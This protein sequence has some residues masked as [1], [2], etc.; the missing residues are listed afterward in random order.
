LEECSHLCSCCGE[1]LIKLQETNYQ[2]Y[3]E[4]WLQAAP[5][6]YN[7]VLCIGCLEEQ[8]GRKLTQEDFKGT[9]YPIYTIWPQSSRLLDRMGM[10]VTE[11]EIGHEF[12]SAELWR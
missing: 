5:F 11:E 6:K 3:D 2:V 1:D 9:T 7:F 10:T 12:L 4:V 8:L